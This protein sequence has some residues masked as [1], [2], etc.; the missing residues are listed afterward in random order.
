VTHHHDIGGVDRGPRDEKLERQIERDSAGSLQPQQ[1]ARDADDCRRK[2]RR[3]DRENT[4]NH[5]DD[6]GPPQLLESRAMPDQRS[7]WAA[8]IRRMQR[9]MSRLH[10]RTPLRSW[11]LGVPD[12]DWRLWRI[13]REWIAQ[14]G[15]TLDRSTG[16]AP[17]SADVYIATQ[18]HEHGGH[19]A[20]IGDFVRALGSGS[21]HL[22]VTDVHEHS[23]ETV[24]ED[25][26]SR[27][28]LPASAITVLRASSL[29]TRVDLLF[30]TLT[31]LRPSRL[32]LFHHPDDPLASVVAQPEV[33]P[34]RVLVHHAD[35][36]PSFGMYLPGVRIV[37]LSPGAAALTRFLGRASAWLPLTA[38]DPATRSYTFLG[39][40]RLTTASC[41][42]AHKF[43][44]DYAFGYPETVGVILRTT[45]GRHVHIG[46]LDDRLRSHIGE[47]L[48]RANVPR[49][50]FVHVP[51]TP[52]VTATLREHRCDVY[53]ASFPIDGARTKIEVMA[54]G[55]PYLGHS[56]RP[57]PAPTDGAA[58]DDTL[59][60]REYED[61]SAILARMA[62][63]AALEE[64][65]RRVRAEYERLH[66]PREFAR[67]L[68]QILDGGPGREDSQWRDRVDGVI[69][70][71]LSSVQRDVNVLT[72]RRTL[73]QRVSQLWRRALA[74]RSHP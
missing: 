71:M 60:W 22:V 41:G 48:R 54:A 14:H 67:Q 19:T 12:W 1:R 3:Q 49:D 16:D 34:T 68:A 9:Q 11:A 59:V 24:S 69:A 17:P 38:P 44:S 50:R 32:F 43:S 15:D 40:G 61:L 46:G 25:V 42:T 45:G 39:D 10:A 65:S 6:Y 33:A 2:E 51:Y 66:H 70:Q 21:T 52:S 47:A 26:R 62:N 56:T 29:S 64:Q 30:R 13:G 63:V 4:R 23:D 58:T 8:E 18:L 73:R 20:L 35:Y 7:Q 28:G 36:L 37:D 31:Q 72:A 74:L 27:L 53:C 55:I 57:Q 5:R